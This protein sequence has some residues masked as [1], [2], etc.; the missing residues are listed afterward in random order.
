[1]GFFLAVPHSLWDLSLPT[2]DPIHTIGSES[3]ESYS[4]DH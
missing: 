3:A 2:M 4:L 1:M